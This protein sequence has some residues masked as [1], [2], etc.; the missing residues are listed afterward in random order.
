MRKPCAAALGFFDGVHAAHLRVLQSAARYAAAHD[1]EP[2]AVTFDRSPKAF[3]TGASA[4]LICTAQERAR[5]MR[6]EAGMARVVML[7]FDAAMRDRDARAFITDIVLGSLGAGYC[8]AGYDYRFGAGGAGDAA[9]LREICAARGVPC[10]IVGCLADG[11]LKISS[12]RIRELIAAG[13]VETAAALLGRPFSLSGEVIHGKAL[14]RTLGFPT[15]NIAIPPELVLPA[16][17]VY[18]CRVAV[19]GAWRR[20]VCNIAHGERPLCEVHAFDYAG[21]AYGLTIRA[22]LLRFVRGMRRFASH[23]E[24]ARQVDCDKKVALNWFSSR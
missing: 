8:A 19:A 12:T 22:E 4:P 16:A 14:G 6:E 3:V 2:V 18:I 10:E 21:D 24:L 20:A 11:G 17:G 15:M 1:M 7:P 13:D 9:L 23:E 5:I